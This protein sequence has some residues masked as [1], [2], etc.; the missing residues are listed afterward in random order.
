[1]GEYLKLS[2]EDISRL[3]KYYLKKNSK[4]QILEK[5]IKS[6]NYHLPP[7]ASSAPSRRRT[8]LRRRS[9]VLCSALQ[10]RDEPVQITHSLR[11]D[12]PGPGDELADGGCPGTQALCAEQGWPDFRIFSSL[13]THKFYPSQHRELADT[14]AR[15]IGSWCQEL[16]KMQPI[17]LPPVFW[18]KIRVMSWPLRPVPYPPVVCCT[19]SSLSSGSYDLS[20]SMRPSTNRGQI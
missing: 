11:K 16:G 6:Q 9:Q 4:V 12:P 20:L 8:R 18:F 13:V 14:S 15:S 2:I 5:L 7:R 17:P 19:R 10:S 1:M 3:R